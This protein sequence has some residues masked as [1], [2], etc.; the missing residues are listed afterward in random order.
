MKKVAILGRPNV[1]KSSLFN[2]L[3]RE[4]DAITSE[5]SGTTRDVKKRILKIDDKECLLIDT[6][7]LDD[8]KEELNKK[9]KEVSLKAASEADI[10]LY[11]VDGQMLADDFDRSFFMDIEKLNKESVLVANKVDSDRFKEMVWE[12]QSFGAKKIFEISV[13]HNRGISALISWL[14]SRLE[15]TLSIEV[16]SEES[17]EDFLDESV[18]EYESKP[19]DVAIIGRVN[20]GKSSLLN[21]LLGEERSVV[22]EIAGTTIDPVDESFIYQ[23]RVINFVDTAGLR[24]RGRIKGIEKY[25]L[26]RTK[27]MLERS[28][29]A[30]L[31][32]DSSSDFVELDERIGG[33]VKEYS[34]GCIVVL[35]KWD[36][37]EEE[38][39]KVLENF[40]K[41]FRYLNFAEILTVSALK[42]RNVEK[43]KD[44]ILKVYANYTK[45]V[46]TSRLN[47]IIQFAYMKHKH[48]S[49]RGKL[50]KFYYATQFLVA[51]PTFMLV[52]NTS[53]KLHFSY[54]RYLQNEIREHI[55][56]K[57]TPI[58]IKTKRRGERDEEPKT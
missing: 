8:E 44:A 17:L 50:V 1:G 6:G 15:K 39:Q 31:V 48:P 56:F 13:A 7:G 57:G 21:A 14:Y 41:K 26:D 27:K 9:I 55:D 34:L 24:R 29:I 33:L 32:L 12:Y 20:V 5:V 51:P 11:M 22:S 2:R 53:Y 30:L 36:I 47:E 38:S 54:Q 18:V 40:K 42:G 49:Y 52:T 25:A 28:D 16:D 35:N 3:I 45:R 10:I 46:P 43:I 37:K 23:D 19:I 58:I 4:F